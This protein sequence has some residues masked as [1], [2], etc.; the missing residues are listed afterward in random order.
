[1]ACASFLDYFERFSVANRNG[2]E[3]KYPLLLMEKIR[4]GMASFVA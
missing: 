4:S 1:M 3:R 2:A